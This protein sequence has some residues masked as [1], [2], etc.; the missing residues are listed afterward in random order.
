MD[1]ERW[2]PPFFEVVALVW[3][4]LL[5]VDY[6]CQ[7]GVF[8]L[9]ESLLGPACVVLQMLLGILILD[10]VLLYRWSE[11]EPRWIARSTWFLILTIMAAAAQSAHCA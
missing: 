5:V 8:T 1:A 7:F 6:S 3:S 4:V 10:V 9:S 2:W 11:R